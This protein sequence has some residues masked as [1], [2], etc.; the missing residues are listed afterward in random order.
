MP[1]SKNIQP[2]SQHFFP[3]NY[4]PYKEPGYKALRFPQDFHC[5]FSPLT[6]K[7]HITKTVLTL[8]KYRFHLLFFGLLKVDFPW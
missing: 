2:S 8:G 1:V 4:L 7:F 6:K 3:S 5:L